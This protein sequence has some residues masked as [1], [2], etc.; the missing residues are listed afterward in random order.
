MT[1]EE[2]LTAEEEQQ[3]IKSFSK[4]VIREKSGNYPPLKRSLDGSLIFFNAAGISSNRG[5]KLLQGSELVTR[6]FLNNSKPIEEDRVFYNGSEHNLLQ[7]RKRVR[8]SSDSKTTEDELDDEDDN[9]Y[10]D[11]SQLVDVRKVLTPISSLADIAKHEPV[12]RPFKS[13][14]LR[15]LALQAVLMIETEQNSVIRYA[16]LLDVFLGD[17]PQPLYESNLHLADYDHNL[18][19]PE[20]EEMDVEE[21]EK[22]ENKDSE[23]KEGDPFFALPKLNGS[24]AILSLLPEANSPE[25]NEEIEV[26]RQLAQIALQRNQEFV[27]NLQKV[28][29]AL[30]KAARIKDRIYAW[31]EEYAGIPQEGV[32]IPNALRVVKRGIISATTNR[33]MGGDLDEEGNSV[34]AGSVAGGPGGDE[35]ET[36]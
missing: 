9:E 25:V 20:E 10:D 11:L 18:R 13:K 36:S 16:K 22:H 6:R 30:I 28:R 31:S 17:Y 29:K 24:D 14:V 21:K 27:R 15:E 1:S 4:R 7:R 26:A 19:L 33:S 12:S 34:D 35:D 23:E 3:Y 32:I 5:N 2:G 8:L